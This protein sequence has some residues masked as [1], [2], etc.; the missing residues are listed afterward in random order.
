MRLLL[1]VIG[2]LFGALLLPLLVEQF[3][4]MTREPVRCDGG[5]PGA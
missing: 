2:F 4:L 3:I 5:N 1:F